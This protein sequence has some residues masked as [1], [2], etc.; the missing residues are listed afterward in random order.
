MSLDQTEL[1]IVQNT[2]TDTEKGYA[3]AIMPIRAMGNFLLCSILLGNV[4]VNNTMTILLD[5]LTGGGGTIAVICSTLGIVV[6]GEIIPQAICSRHGLAVGAKTILLTK[7]FMLVTAPLSFPISKILDC[8]LGTEIGTVYNKQRLMEL[9]KVTEQYNGL[10]K[11]EIN[12]VTGA[13]VLKQKCVKDVMTN[14]EDCYMLPIESILDFETISEIKEQGYSRIPVYQGGDRKKVVYI[15]FAKDLLFVDPDDEK[16][17]EEICKFYQNDVNFV[18]SDTILT[19]MFDEFKSGEKGH[20][21]L[22]QEV[23]NDGDSDPFYETVGLVTLE[24]IIEEIIQQEIVDE[25]DVVIDNKSKKKRKRERFKKDAEVK[26]FQG[27]KHAVTITPHENMAVLQF[28]TTSVGAF[29]PEHI[30]QTILK[31]LLTMDVFREVKVNK[32]G[33][34]NEEL[35]VI[36]AM[37]KPCDY[38][39]MVIEGKVEVTIGKEERRFQDGPFSCY[40]EPMLSQT[41]ANL[42]PASP[43]VNGTGGRT[44]AAPSAQLRKTNTQQQLN[45]WIPDYNVRALTDLVYL[46]VRRNTYLVAIKASRMAQNSNPISEHELS[47]AFANVMNNDVE[48]DLPGR[49]PMVSPEKGSSSDTSD[50]RRESLRSSLNAMK[51]KILGAGER[52]ED[53]WDGTAPASSD[54]ENLSSDAGSSL[55]S[56]GKKENGDQEQENG[57]ELGPKSLPSLAPLR[58]NGTLPP[59]KRTQAANAVRRNSIAKMGNGNDGNGVQEGGQEKTTNGNTTVILVRGNTEEEKD[60]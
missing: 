24:D 34:E 8:I 26:M 50:L 14:I 6:F 32:E 23:N 53:F 13:L 29:S 59:V 41:L 43:M 20:L 18:Y 36:M 22:V 7:F 55:N 35:P 1:K 4:L 57:H 30:R 21:A 16:P 48:D 2:G 5:V 12:I 9:L 17:I 27:A 38:F 3:T 45:V 52:K 49:T 56:G 28:L 31:K 54:I 25:T 44:S 37:G 60:S 42:N 39:L 11:D 40:G 15:L 19:D 47:N 58:E 46:K 10:E 33:K 51:K